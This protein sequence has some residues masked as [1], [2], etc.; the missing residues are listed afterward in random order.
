M[1]SGEWGV[2]SGEGS[3]FARAR[4]L[5]VRD[6]RAFFAPFRLSNEGYDPL[7][8]RY[9]LLGGHYRSQMQFS[10]ES[11]NGAKNARKS[12][13]DKIRALSENSSRRGAEAQR[14]EE[15]QILSSSPLATSQSLVPTNK[16]LQAFD[17][18]LEDDLNT[19]RALAELWGLLRDTSIEP[20]AAL[21]AAFD[22]DKAL[23]LRLEDT[24][25]T[26]KQPENEEFVL[27][28][29]KIIAERAEAKKSKDFARADCLRLILKEK[30]IVLEDGPGGTT[31]RKI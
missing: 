21:A 20:E 10:F 13:T 1:A 8:Y 14:K 23:G 17:K 6:L 4:I 27:E 16:Y 30:N 7:D 25:Y 12:L 24:L 29:E 18:A 31:W 22:M 3:P 15:M 5:S 11:L 19:P 28:V 26:E 9:F 2:G